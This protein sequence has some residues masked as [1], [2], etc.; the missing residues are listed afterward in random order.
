M[1]DDRLVNRVV[2]ELIEMAGKIGWL[3]DLER[4]LEGFGWR[5]VG[6]ETLGRLSMT[7]IG[8]MLRNIA[9]REVKKEWEAEA[10]ERSRLEVMRGLLWVPAEV[11][12]CLEVPGCVRGYC[13]KITQ[14]LN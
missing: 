2:M 6:V 12:M 9:W 7:E 10:W 14:S 5:D 13:S 3:K 8:H 4:G 11:L 1:G